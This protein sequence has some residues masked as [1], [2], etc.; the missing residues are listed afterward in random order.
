MAAAVSATYSLAASATETIALGL[1]HADDPST[2]HEL[3][4]HRGTLNGTSTPAV[5]KVYSG[6]VTLTAGQAPLDLTALAGPCSTTV[7]FTN[8]KVQIIK[9]ACLSTNTAGITVAAKDSTTGYNLFGATNATVAAQSLYPQWHLNS[10]NGAVVDLLNSET[11]TVIFV[12]GQITDGTHTPTVEESDTGV[13]AWTTVGA[14]DMIGTLA[15]L[16]TGVAQVVKYIGVK[17]YLRCYTTVA[18]GPVTGGVYSSAI[19]SETNKYNVLPGAAVE[20][21]TDDEVEDVDATHKDLIITGAGV[22]TIEVLLVAG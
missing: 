22:E 20:V 6:T 9:L 2:S 13:G 16:A 11:A 19:V 1:T 17:R 10:V 21:V 4:Q 14:G 18:G 8:L 12:V 5:T 15:V 7:D 3:T